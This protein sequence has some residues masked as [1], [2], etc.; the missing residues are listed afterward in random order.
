MNTTVALLLTQDGL[1]NGLIY[2]L[3]ALAILLVFLVTRVLWVPAGDFVVSSALTM[4]LLGLGRT[5]GS[6]WLLLILGVAAF[7]SHAW[8]SARMREWRS[9]WIAAAVYIGYP[10]LMSAL[11]PLMVAA[12]LSVI[13]RALVTLLLVAPMGPMIYTAVFRP[14]EGS[15]VLIKLIAAVA[16]DMVLIGAQL[17]VFGAEGLRSAPLVKGR[18][19]IGFTSVSMQL[20]LVLLVSV[21]LMFVL[22]Y[23]FS[24]TLWGKALRAIAMNARG[25]RFVGIRTDSAGLL[26]FGIAGAVG[27]LT[28]IL[29]GPIA[30]VYY[31]SGFAIS[32]KG[33]IGVVFAGMLSFPG[34]VLASLAVGLF[35]SFAGFFNSSLRDVLVF[36]LLIPMLMW[37]SL[38]APKHEGNE[39]QW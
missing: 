26:A 14:L 18:I 38:G 1:T 22:G 3:L 17:F 19:D 10:I 23:F 4:G 12:K 21:T 13:L 8:R 25:A 11:V 5:P 6:I 33:F 9:V 37:R 34:S 15:S 16:L 32:L 36:A 29:I 2:A 7:V 28:G 24:R 39:E 27:A 20:L 35:D 30:T 31:D